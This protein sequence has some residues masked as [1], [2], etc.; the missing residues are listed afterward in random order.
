MAKGPIF[1]RNLLMPVLSFTES[2]GRKGEQRGE[3]GRSQALP[4]IF[5]NKELVQIAKSTPRV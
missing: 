2:L 4:C 3:G 5:E 1:R